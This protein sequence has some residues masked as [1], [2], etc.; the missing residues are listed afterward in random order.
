MRNYELG[1]I[2]HP[3]VDQPDVP[4]AVERVGQYVA[5]GG[6][7][8]T[9]VDVWGRRDLAYPIRKYQEGTYVFLEAQLDPQ[10]IGSG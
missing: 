10:A 8:V 2:L 3:Q 5:A 1:L 9:S 7:A 6:G 4:Q